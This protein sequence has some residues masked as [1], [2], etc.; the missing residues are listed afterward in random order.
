MVGR[1][2]SEEGA[3]ARTRLLLR[4]CGGGDGQ[5]RR[6]TTKDERVE[7]RGRGSGSGIGH[8][9]L[10]DTGVKAWQG[11]PVTLTG[12]SRRAG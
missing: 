2:V 5:K 6:R 4:C 11:C 9:L 10:L 3:M 1:G 12:S 7:W 8:L